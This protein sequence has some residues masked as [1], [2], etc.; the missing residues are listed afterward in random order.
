V[1]GFRQWYAVAFGG[2]V[3][4][5]RGE[6]DSGGGGRRGKVVEGWFNRVRRDD[7]VF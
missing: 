6:V 3:G 5:W 2:S 4:G 7:Q 1:G